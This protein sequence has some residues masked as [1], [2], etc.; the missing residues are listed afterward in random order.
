[1]TSTVSSQAGRRWLQSQRPATTEF[2]NAPTAEP[3]ATT[4]EIDL[5]DLNAID[6]APMNNTAVPKSATTTPPPQTFATK[7]IYDQ[8]HGSFQAPAVAHM[9]HLMIPDAGENKT[10]QS[11]HAH[12]QPQEHQIV[13]VNIPNVAQPA[14][15]VSHTEMGM[16]TSRDDNAPVS[17]A[18]GE[19][20]S[21]TDHQPE[22]TT[23]T[24]SHGSDVVK[25]VDSIL[26]RFP[27][28]APAV[29]LFVGPEEN[30][31]VDE[32]CAR[33]AAEISS[34]KVGNVLLVDADIDGQRLT[35]AS[36]MLGQEG[37]AEC[38]NRNLPWRE[39]VVS[40]DGASF[41]FLPA[42]ACP[43]DRWNAKQLLVNSAA[44]MKQDFQFVCVS[45]GSAH[46]A[47]ARLWYDICDGSYLVVSLKSTN[48]TMA[49]S[50]VNE[51]RAAGARL[52]G[53][54]VTD[55]E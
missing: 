30:P 47:Q 19:A 53:C 32:T 38:I 28:A 44:E 49:K 48:E 39:T 50:S 4:N 27:L 18:T 33:V 12:D 3:T 46:S 51:M 43:M 31:H 1:M 35:R 26:E 41:G 7:A 15:S 8:L 22:T 10:A 34:R 24:E 5:T 36:G 14:E 45:G 52:L 9:N 37:F 55:V 11:A 2:E 6:V 23:E 13:F 40:R 20:D 17:T 25:L 54:V 16:T 42:G 21:H 29:L